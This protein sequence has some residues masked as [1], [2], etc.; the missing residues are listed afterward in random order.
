[1]GKL[2][3]LFLMVLICTSFYSY[4][5]LPKVSEM[6]S[7]FQTTMHN[8]ELCPKSSNYVR[9]SQISPNVKNA[10]I[11][12]EDVA[13]YSHHGF[14]YAEMKNSFQ[15]NLKKLSFARGGSTITQQL[16]KN[17]Y[18]NG[19]KTLTRKIKEVILTKRIEEKF[20][21]NVILE[22]YLNV[23]EFGTD[24]YGIK[25]ASEHYFQ[26]PPSMISPLEAAFIAFL[27]PNPEKYSVSFKN[28]ELTPFARERI[29]NILFKLNHYKKITDAEY[30]TARAQ[31]QVM[32]KSIPGME[33]EPGLDEYNDNTDLYD[34]TEIQKAQDKSIEKLDAVPDTAPSESIYP[35][36][37]PDSDTL[38]VK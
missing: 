12:S 10:V 3:I 19:E 18:L 36:Q 33:D 37:I 5:T 34:M 11:I 24:I 38:E 1:M 7:C 28:K 9:L 14:D 25:A 20:S 31:L 23:V 21:K 6:E 4:V 2:F 32:F 15:K 22:K 29:K 26:K 8:V 27:L 13:F 16:A 30:S 17:L 35:D